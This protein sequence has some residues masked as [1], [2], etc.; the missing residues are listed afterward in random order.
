VEVYL[1][2]QHRN[3][4]HTTLVHKENSKTK[5]KRLFQCLSFI[6]LVCHKGKCPLCRTKIRRGV[7]LNGYYEKQVSMD[8][9]SH[10]KPEFGI[11]IVELNNWQ[12]GRPA[13]RQSTEK[14]NTYQ[15]L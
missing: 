10:K 8:L 7:A 12:A 15:L 2:L 9:R 11:S 6:S 1:L 14:H 13:N 5:N 3:S 4:L